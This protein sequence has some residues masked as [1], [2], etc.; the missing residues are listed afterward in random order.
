MALSGQR[1]AHAAI[2]L[3]GAIRLFWNAYPSA[4]EL[5]GGDYAATN[6]GVQ[7]AHGNTEALALIFD[8]RVF[9]HQRLILT[10][11]WALRSI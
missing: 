9:F 6:E 10:A 4:S 5:V 1:P 11:K 2:Q 8:S 3:K 7:M